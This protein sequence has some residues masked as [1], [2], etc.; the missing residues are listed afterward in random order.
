MA[1][2][3]QTLCTGLVI[4]LILGIPARAG[5]TSNVTFS[6]AFQPTGQGLLSFTPNLG[7][8]LTIGA[9]NGANGGLIDT[10]NTGIFLPCLTPGC[11]VVGGYLTL[12]SG[13]ETSGL[14]LPGGVLYTFGA[15]GELDVYGGIPVLGVANGSHLFSA[16][17]LAGDTF[18][19]TAAGAL[20]TG[21][22]TGALDLTSIILNPQLGNF[23]W[24]G[25]STLENS[26]DLNLSCATLGNAC[27]GSVD[28]VVSLQTP[29]PEPGTASLVAAGLV[30]FGA[31]LRKRRITR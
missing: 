11:A 22:F 9:G 2:P 5:V 18:L 15:G 31:R 26:F 16:T 20:A 17:F 10:Y 3:I 25:G 30:A 1:A 29:T 24:T 8:A 23:A 7:D 12:T 13:P 4:C 19:V 6:G 28:P 21:T 27:S 14:A